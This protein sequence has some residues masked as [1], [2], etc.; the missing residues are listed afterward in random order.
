MGVGVCLGPGLGS[1]W[2]FDLEDLQGLGSPTD[3]SMSHGNESSSGTQGLGDLM[4][5]PGDLGPLSI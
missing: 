1:G 5:E 3:D 4:E 2:A